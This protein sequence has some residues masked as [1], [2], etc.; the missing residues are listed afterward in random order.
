MENILS[1]ITKMLRE[2]GKTIVLGL[3]SI[4]VFILAWHTLAWYLKDT[5]S[6]VAYLMP[7]PAEVAEAFIDSFMSRDPAT[8]LYM[9]DHIISSLKRIVLGFML[10][11]VI[12][13]PAGMLMGAMKGAEAIG[14]PIVEIFRPIPPLAW[15][16]LS[17][18]MFGIIWGPIWI[19]FLGIFFPIL[20]SVMFGVRSVDTVLIDAAK[21]LGA[22]RT[23][24]FTK[25]ILPYT[26]PYLMTGIKVGLGIGWMCIVAAEMMGAV[27]GGVGYYIWASS[28]VGRYEYMYAGMAV[29]GLVSVLT[30]GIA[31]QIERR[32]YKW[33]GMK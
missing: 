25:V 16:P 27:G 1:Q 10:A 9:H 18:L 17:M 26:L 11:L 22:R 21:T 14:K 7:Y 19:V 2:N 3:L 5:G 4:C 33:M 13:L 29:I 24:V 28:T 20:L 32:V 31:G 12:A 6:S 8:H 15:I 23:D 30:T